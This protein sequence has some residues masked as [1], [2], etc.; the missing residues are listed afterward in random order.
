MTYDVPS[1][2]SMHEAVESDPID[3]ELATVI[4]T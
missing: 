2:I 1:S 3:V 4:S